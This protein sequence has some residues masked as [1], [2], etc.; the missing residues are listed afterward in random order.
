[1]PI[2]IIPKI[3][4]KLDGSDFGPMAHPPFSIDVTEQQDNN[5]EIHVFRGQDGDIDFNS[6]VAAML[7]SDLRVTIN[8]QDLPP[9]T[10]WHYV[11]RAYAKDCGKYSDPS[12]PCIVIIDADG[13]MIGLS[14][15]KPNSIIAEPLSGG[16]IRLRWRYSRFLQEAAPTGFKIYMDSGEGFDLNSPFDEVGY[17][18]KGEFFWISEPLDHGKR[19]KFIVRSYKANYGES[20]NTNIVSAIADAFGPGPIRDLQLSWLEI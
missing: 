18:F 7:S 12:P 3:D 8:E 11:R 4:G 6:P 5:V 1:M 16:R 20:Q 19:Y 13:N 17:Y 14:P 15:N 9:N 2:R 10:I